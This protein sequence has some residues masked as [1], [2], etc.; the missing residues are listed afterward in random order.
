MKKIQP[1]ITAA[2]FVIALAASG[3]GGHSGGGGPQD[4][5]NTSVVEDSQFTDLVFQGKIAPVQETDIEDQEAEQEQLYIEDSDTIND[6]LTEHPESCDPR[7]SDPSS[8]EPT[9]SPQADG[10]F[11][12]TITLRN[13]RK[14]Q[15]VTMGRRNTFHSIAEGIK[16]FPTR[17]NQLGIYR[18]IYENLS[19]DLISEL[20]LVDPDIIETHPVEYPVS[21][22]VNLNNRFTY[23]DNTDKIIGS[24]TITPGTL[25]NIFDCSTDYGNGSNGDR[26]DCETTCGFQNGG[27]FKNYT[28]NHK[29]NLTCVKNQGRR[30]TCCAF[31][32]ISATEYWV[33]RKLDT[34]V[35]LSEQALYNQMLFNWVRR[36]YGDGYY[37]SD[38]LDF[39]V[40]NSYLIPFEN[41][42][43]YNASP[44]RVDVLNYKK[45]LV[46]YKYSCYNYGETCSNTTHQSGYVCNSS[47]TQCGYQVPDINPNS[48]G[49]RLK[50][51]HVIWDHNDRATSFAR[52]LIYLAMGD[53]V[54]IQVPVLDQ[55]DA[56]FETGY[57]NYVA[58]DVDDDSIGKKS[59]NRGNHIMHVVSYIDNND[60]SEL[61]PGA[62]EGAGGGYL[63]VK[64][65]WTN[66]WGDGGYI[67]LPYN[68]I[69]EYT[70]FASV[71][72]A[73]RIDG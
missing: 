62:P 71:L 37:I 9:V 27:I 48:Q 42:W 31:A 16:I 41:Q 7:P 26:T 50:S 35:N 1:F 72:K 10:N 34:R 65:S 28:W 69:K 8:D 18:G 25:P 22:I 54:L 57:V 63:I 43:N 17:S 44:N 40:Q 51:S 61:V 58:G 3:C 68:F 32:V 39:A 59:T 47:G 19:Q 64:N 60:L 23:S 11:L 53:P 12:H 46:N 45:D 38:T 29:G 73:I 4:T 21:T 56:A 14:T 15:V 55:F 13:G 6:F 30:G 49:Y 5:I 52:I 24:I 2:I 67:Y 20:E 66:C 33:G 70:Q 36:D